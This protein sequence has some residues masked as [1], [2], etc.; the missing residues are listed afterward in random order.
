[1]VHERFCPPRRL[2]DAEN[3]AK[4]K[5]PEYRTTYH[6]AHMSEHL[7]DKLAPLR[8]VKRSV[9]AEDAPRA[10]QAISSHLQLVHGV[11]ILDVELHARAVRRFC[12]PHIQVFMPSCLEVQSVVT[13][14]KVSKFRQE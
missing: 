5:R 8:L 9:K 3:L 12:C 2:R 10:L 6:H 14:V 13:V 4:R 7:L 11:D 1:M